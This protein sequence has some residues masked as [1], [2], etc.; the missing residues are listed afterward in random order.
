MGVLEEGGRMGWIGGE[1]MDGKVSPPFQPERCIQRRRLSIMY[2][3][4]DFIRYLT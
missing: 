1:K 3:P 2:L 4:P